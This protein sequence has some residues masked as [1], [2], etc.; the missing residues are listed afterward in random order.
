[1]VRMPTARRAAPTARPC[2]WASSSPSRLIPPTLERRRSA[3]AHGA[4][5]YPPLEIANAPVT[6]EASV[7][8]GG[9]G[10]GR[11]SAEHHHRRHRL[12][13]FSPCWCSRSAP[14]ACSSGHAE[15]CHR[16][17]PRVNLREPGR[18][19]GS[20]CQIGGRRA[21]VW[22]VRLSLIVAPTRWELPAPP[23]SAPGGRRGIADGPA[24]VR[25]QHCRPEV[26]AVLAGGD[27]GDLFPPLLPRSAPAPADDELGSARACWKNIRPAMGT[28]G[29]SVR[30][31]AQRHT[32]GRRG[33]RLRL[34]LPTLASRTCSAAP[35]GAVS[36]LQIRFAEPLHQPCRRRRLAGSGF[37][38]PP[39][40]VTEYFVYPLNPPV[41]PEGRIWRL[42]PRQAHHAPSSPATAVSMPIATAAG[43][44]TVWNGWL[45]ADRFPARCFLP[46]CPTLSRLNVLAGWYTALPLEMLDTSLHA[47]ARYAR[48]GSFRPARCTWAEQAVPVTRDRSRHTVFRPIVASCR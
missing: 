32:H 44:P 30:R 33:D 26:G 42:L 10:H 37:L 11:P 46:V 40:T 2:G 9:E 43:N 39:V 1:M 36:G 38:S 16:P 45:D 14:G 13:A 25:P 31:R 3:H 48:R 22:A 4:A 5:E 18:C 29:A 8:V 27:A 7:V 24:T 41:L 15:E 21:A 47:H 12:Q 17:P 28:R 20:Q 19:G 34:A 6:V 23:P 35:S